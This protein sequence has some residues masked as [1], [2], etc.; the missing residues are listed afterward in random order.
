[1]RLQLIRSL[2]F[3]ALFSHLV[4]LARA[5]VTL[6]TIDGLTESMVA[7]RRRLL[8]E[9]IQTPR[10]RQASRRPRDADREHRNTAAALHVLGQTLLHELN[11]PV[12]PRPEIQ[13]ATAI[14]CRSVRADF[15]AFLSAG[16]N[17]LYVVQE[18]QMWW[19]WKHDDI[20]ENLRWLQALWASRKANATGRSFIEQQM[21]LYSATGCF[22]GNQD[23]LRGNV[24]MVE[25]LNDLID[26]YR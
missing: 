8:D 21:Q 23:V 26:T 18:E 17:F 16:V 3:G 10:A 12:L 6:D 25:Y 5:R 24:E 14:D 19:Q 13:Y 9:D 7:L 15:Y 22:V 4:S 2:F 1:M 11:R 20:A